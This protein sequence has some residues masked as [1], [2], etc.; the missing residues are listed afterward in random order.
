V[1]AVVYLVLAVA[2]VAILRRI[3]RGATP[4]D[5]APVAPARD[6]VPA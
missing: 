4:P 2:L 5:P 3:A 1:T 6:E